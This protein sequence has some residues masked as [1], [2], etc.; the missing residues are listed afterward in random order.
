MAPPG[1]ASATPGAKYSP[2]RTPISARLTPNSLDSSGATAATLWNWNA[3]VA[4]T[5]NRTARIPQR[6]RNVRPLEVAT[7]PETA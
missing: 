6:L 5:A 4:R 2:I 3:M 7:Q 1:N